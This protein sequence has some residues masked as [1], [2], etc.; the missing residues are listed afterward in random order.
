MP[1]Y[2]FGHLNQK[3]AFDIII[4]ISKFKKNCSRLEKW[5]L[6]L[7]NAL[8]WAIR[9]E[10]GDELEDVEDDD[11]LELDDYEYFIEASDVYGN[12]HVFNVTREWFTMSNVPRH[13]HPPEVSVFFQ[14]Y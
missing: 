4:T 10:K 7:E 5:N 11:D 14:L 1:F 13:S 9:S 6:L 8:N 2:T 3:N 12:V